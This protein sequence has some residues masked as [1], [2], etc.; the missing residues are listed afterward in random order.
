MNS[1]PCVVLDANIWVSQMLLN[2]SIGAAFLYRLRKIQ[3]VIGLPEVVEMEV[4]TQVLRKAREAR[5]TVQ[6]NLANI[7]SLVG[8][9]QE[10]KLPSDEEFTR[11][12]EERFSTLSR[13]IQRIPI[14]PSHYRQA[15][16]NVIDGVAPNATREQYRDSLIWEAVK[17]LSLSYAVNL[18]T[19]DKD[20]Y[21][22]KD[23][24]KGL[25]TELKK[26]ADPAPE[27]ALFKDL[28]QYLRSFKEQVAPPEYDKIA[29][30]ITNELTENRAVLGWAEKKHFSIDRLIGHSIQAFVTER[31]GVLAISFKLTYRILNVVESHA[32]ED[33]K[34][35]ELEEPNEHAEARLV[36]S[37][38]CFFHEDTETASELRAHDIDLFA[39]DGRDI[40]GLGGGYM[41]AT[42]NV[43]GQATKLHR[44]HRPI[45]QV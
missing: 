42:I 29:L 32:I 30:V 6:Q 20:F 21:D 37:G 14:G 10:L 15:L 23:Y 12:I 16:V 13:F 8:E 19:N 7:R 25:A 33:G 2:S 24:A 4:M 44:V 43:G 40:V 36:C 41:Y 5:E 35:V 39:L 17:D 18:I 38:D 31:V 1:K 22:S 3:G 45:D 9:T 11:A 34:L 26:H 27:I 28:E